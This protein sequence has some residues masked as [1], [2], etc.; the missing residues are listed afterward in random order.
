MARL[1]RWRVRSDLL[2]RVGEALYGLRWQK[3]MAHDLPVSRAALRRWAART[4][5]APADVYVDCIRLVNERM[6]LLAELLTA[7]E[8]AALP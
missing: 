4:D 1:E 5:E 8:E 6:T 7:L 3:A 2:T